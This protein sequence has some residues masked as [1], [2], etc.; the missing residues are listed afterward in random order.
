MYFDNCMLLAC[1]ILDRPFWILFFP[2]VG[3]CLHRSLGRFS[4][5]WLGYLSIYV[6]F[7]PDAKA[8]G[9]CCSFEDGPSLPSW[10]S[11]PGRVPTRHA[12]PPPP[13]TASNHDHR[14]PPSCYQRPCPL[15]SPHPFPL[16]PSLPMV[17]RVGWR[18]Q[19]AGCT[20]DCWW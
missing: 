20:R 5:S 13:S 6:L 9:H 16:S 14:Q 4:Q 12:S 17:L 15:V 18:R 3:L 1:I 19:H 11:P 2:S 7:I 10:V 8:V